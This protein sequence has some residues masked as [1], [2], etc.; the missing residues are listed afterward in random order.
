MPPRSWSA[1]S[2]PQGGFFCPELGGFVIYL[3]LIVLVVWRGDGI[4]AGTNGMTIE[5]KGSLALERARFSWGEAAP[6]LV[7]VACFFLFPNY[8]VFGASV[9]TMALFAVSLDLI[10]GFAGVLTLGHG[11]FYGSAPTP[12]GCLRCTVCMSRSRTRC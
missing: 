1:S 5:V 8:L 12:R 10:I 9:L 4:F 3:L 6:L 7:G 11:V 2:T